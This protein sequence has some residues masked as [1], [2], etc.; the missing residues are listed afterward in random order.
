MDKKG[1]QNWLRFVFY[2]HLDLALA[3]A[4]DLDLDAA[5]Y[6]AVNSYHIYIKIIYADKVNLTHVS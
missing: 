6:F 5:F 1:N 4:L 2:I 3:L